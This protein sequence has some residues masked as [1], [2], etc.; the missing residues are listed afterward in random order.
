MTYGHAGN[1]YDNFG[2]NIINDSVNSSTYRKWGTDYS[3]MLQPAWDEQNNVSCALNI[4]YSPLAS[5]GST[6]SWTNEFTLGLN[7]QI[8]DP[9][10]NYATGSDIVSDAS[11]HFTNGKIT[12]DNAGN[13]VQN[14]ISGQYATYRWSIGSGT[15]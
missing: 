8:T 4:R 3:V 13:V 12:D 9:Y 14:G 1:G 10:Y 6:I 2:Y 11:G 7:G 5:A 15:S